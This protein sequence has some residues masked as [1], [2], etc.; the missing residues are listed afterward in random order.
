[1]LTLKLKFIKMKRKL[2]MLVA[3]LFTATTVT[4][5]QDFDPKFGA[6]P[7]DRENNVK[8]LNQLQ[9]SYMMKQYDEVLVLMRPLIEKCPKATP[10]LYIRGVEIYRNKLLKATS[11]EDR[12]KYLDSMMILYDQRAVA[13][14]DHPKQ[15]L[16]YIKEQ[17]AKMFFDFAP[18][19]VERA[20]KYFREAIEVSGTKIDPDVLVAFFNMLTDS[21]KL[22]DLTPEAYLDDYEYLTTLLGKEPS[23]E[24]EP[25]LAAI[26]QLFVSSGAANC[27]NI[28]KIFRPKYEAAKT[29]GA[30][31]KKILGLFQRGKCNNDFQFSLLEQYY[32]TDPT[33]EMAAMLA[34]AYEDRKDFTKA[35]SFIEIAIASES[36][37]KQKVNYYL[38][39]ASANLTMGNYRNAA[40]LSRKAIAIDEASPMA[41]FVYANAMAG[42]VSQACSDFDRQAAYWLVVDLYRNALK[43]IGEDEGIRATINSAIN[44]YSGNFIKKEDVF[45]YGL[46]EGAA[47]TVNCGWISG[48]TTVRGR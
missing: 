35:L 37:P 41:H 13:F 4:T 10:N 31:I 5:A 1:M 12:T 46:D 43:Y 44:S 40:D 42:G 22:D 20:T 3:L 29:D 23:P 28:E 19:E 7:A 39:A 15:G 30:L 48:R 6:D 26:E 36:D 33:P 2:Y 45:M 11:K 47:Y 21:F 25:A 16:P 18:T 32:K 38:R 27:E 34:S 17:K 8:M 14:G 9:D 24:T